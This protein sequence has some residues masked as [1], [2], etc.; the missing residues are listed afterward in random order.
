MELKVGNFTQ[1]QLLLLNNLENNLK[2]FIKTLLSN[3]PNR[4]LRVGVGLMV[5]DGCNTDER[6]KIQHNASFNL[7]GSYGVVSEIQ[8]FLKSAS[9]ETIIP[10]GRLIVDLDIQRKEQGKSATDSKD[11]LLLFPSNPKYTLSQIILPESIRQDILDALKIIKCKNLIYD[12]WGFGKIDPVPR[13]VLNFYGEPGTGKTMTAHAIADYLGK[14][15][16]L[17][18]YAE[19][20]SKYVGEAPK[21]LQKAFDVAKENDAVLFFDEADSF[22]GKRIQNVTHGSD[23]ALNSLRSQM[24]ILLEEFPGVVI[25]ATNLVTN[26]DQAFESRILKHIHFS[27]PNKEARADIIA[28]ML[29]LQLPIDDTFTQETL[30]VESEQI[31]GFSGREI[32]NAVLDMLLTRADNF[33][34]ND[35][36]SISDLHAALVKKVESKRQLKS[37]RD[38]LIKEKILKSLKAK[39]MEEESITEKKRRRNRSNNKKKQR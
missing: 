21:N 28:K 1:T 37:E 34:G 31:E 38:K 14:K 17:L 32:K 13:S 29:P 15:I 30:L 22:L 35:K 2:E 16:L 19:I 25:F 23:Q 7:E 18:N 36:F 5:T 20:E 24:L 11:E 26:F 39:V 27:L 4:H 10:T 9:L 8:C 6:Y 3:A 33:N 12:E